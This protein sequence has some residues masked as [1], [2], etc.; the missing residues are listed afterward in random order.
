LSEPFQGQ[1]SLHRCAIRQQ[2]Q[3]RVATRVAVVGSLPQIEENNLRCGNRLPGFAQRRLRK[4]FQSAHNPER[5]GRAGEDLH[6]LVGIVSSNPQAKILSH[7][8]RVRI[9]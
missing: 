7:R 4:Q 3:Q 6:V 8:L 1:S 5:E 2:G 9:L